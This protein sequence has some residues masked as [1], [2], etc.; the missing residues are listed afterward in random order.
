MAM[1]YTPEQNGAA[2]RENRTL[3]E[4]GRS[5]LH[6]KDLP[7]KL[8]AEAVNTAAYILNRTGPTSVN[9]KT[10]FELWF[11][12]ESTPIEH[13]KIFGIECYVHVPKQKRQKWDEKGQKGIF[14]RYCDEKDGYQIW[15]QDKDT[16]IRS[17]NVIFKS[18]LSLCQTSKLKL[19]TN[20][21]KSTE[22]AK[23][24]KDRCFQD[25]TDEELPVQEDVGECKQKKEEIS[26]SSIHQPAGSQHKLR[27]RKLLK[28]PQRYDEYAM[29]AESCPSSFDDAMDSVEKLHWK[30]AMDDEMQS[31]Q[32]NQ[33]WKLVQLP[34]GKRLVDNRWV[35]RIKTKADGSVD[36]FKARLVA[37]SYMQK[38]GTDYDEIFSPVAR[39][40]TVRTIISVAANERMHLAQFDVKTAFLYGKLEEEVV[41]KQPDGYDDGT[42]RVCLLIKSLYGLKQAPRCW[43][44]QFIE[45]IKAQ[46]LR[47][48]D[49]DP[50]MFYRIKDGRKFIVVIYVDDG[51]MAATDSDE[52]DLFLE[53]LQRKFK[54]T[55][56][57]VDCFLGMQIKRENDGSISINQKTY[58]SKILDLICKNQT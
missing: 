25:D 13:F 50:C 5:M 20:S 53:E 52:I 37:K 32:E 12:K 34:P 38:P 15:I 2:E 35:L 1:P 55:A 42:G 21:V 28:C 45:F 31:L 39:F 19:N 41:M 47:A 56:G 10:P 44:K 18:E 43:N 11:G 29:M 23:V 4:S 57:S 9:E 14:I 26:C 46:G 22:E 40:D 51:L 48:S 3:V 17:C 30:E 16:V 49:A 33:T 27:D 36:R 24:D 7:L 58:T 6:A 8:W 54:I